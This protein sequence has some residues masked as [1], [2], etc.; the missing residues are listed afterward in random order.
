MSSLWLIACLA[1]SASAILVSGYR[2]LRW[3]RS[4][5]YQQWRQQ[6][7]E[8]AR[9][10]DVNQ[11]GLRPGIPAP[12][13]ALPRVGGGQRS[14]SDFG[15]R[16]VLVVFTESDCPTSHR[17]A[18]ELNRLQR[19]R[20]IQILVIHHAAPHKAALWADDV[21][22]GFPVLVPSGPEVS[23]RYRVSSTPSAF[24]IDEQGVIAAS[25]VITEPAFLHYV[26][27]AAADRD[28]EQSAAPASTAAGR[29]PASQSHIPQELVPA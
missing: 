21:L 22:A 10:G 9:T 6:Q 11:G 4:R 27:T 19:S 29:F 8:A 2:L 16:R 7:T 17:I 5:G 26:L 13:F 15:G 12:D 25:A 14:L 3:I 23:K 28:S 1:S 18:A 20:N 24:V